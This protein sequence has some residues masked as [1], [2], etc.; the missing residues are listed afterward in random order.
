MANF[1]MQYVSSSGVVVVAMRRGL[2][3]AQKSER[4]AE[5]EE[6][7]HHILGVHLGDLVFV[8]VVN[9]PTADLESC[10]HQTRFWRPLVT[11]V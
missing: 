5:D 8:F 7:A 6:E 1:N 10:R 3:K 11:C 4:S 2:H 9:V